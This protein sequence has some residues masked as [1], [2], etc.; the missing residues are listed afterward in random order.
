[1]L[2]LDGKRPTSRHYGHLD[3]SRHVSVLRSGQN[4]LTLKGAKT[5]GSRALDAGLYTLE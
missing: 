5:K 4:T 2:T 3:L 1:M